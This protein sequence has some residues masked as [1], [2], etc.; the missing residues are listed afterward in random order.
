M[1]VK[2]QTGQQAPH[3]AAESTFHFLSEKAILL[4]FVE[5][6]MRDMS[7]ILYQSFYETSDFH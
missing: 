6:N 5:S 3:S 2:G 4:M 7:L 1:R